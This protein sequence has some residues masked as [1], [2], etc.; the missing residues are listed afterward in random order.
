MWEIKKVNNM[1][2]KD[3]MK[4]EPLQGPAEASSYYYG[5]R[6]NIKE[7]E[8]GWE[9]FKE[10]QQR[11]LKKLED[12]VMGVRKDL[13]EIVDDMQVSPENEKK[14]KRVLNKLA[15]MIET[16]ADLANETTTDFLPA[17]YPATQIEYTRRMKQETRDRAAED[18]GRAKKIRD[19]AKKLGE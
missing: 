18:R 1:T 13:A 4:R 10:K 8:E 3:I 11:N 5:N 9:E 16:Y 2:W 7:V 17:D 14:F 15:D 19:R 12:G 6:P